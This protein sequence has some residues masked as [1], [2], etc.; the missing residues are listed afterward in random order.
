MANV[1][2]VWIGGS[3]DWNTPLDWNDDI[4]PDDA[5]TGSTTDVTL[6]GSTAYTVTISGGENFTVDSVSITDP[7]AMLVVD[8]ALTLT[9]T[10]TFAWGVSGA[11]TLALAG[12]SST[13][14]RGANL[15]VAAWSISGV[16]TSVSVNEA[17]TYSGSFSEA[18][19]ATLSLSGVPGT[20]LTLTGSASFTGGTVNG[21]RT[22]NTEGT[23]T[24]SGLTIGGTVAWTNTK[25]VTQSG[26]DVT[27]GDATGD[28]AKLINNAGA[29]YDITDASDIYRGASAQSSIHN[30][31]TF[32]K[33]STS[34]VS[35]IK[36]NFVDVGT[37]VC[38]GGNL[39]FD[40]AHNS[41][42]GTYIGP[43]MFDY[44]PDGVSTL[45][46]LDLTHS[47]C[48]TNFGVVD[49]TG[50]V[51]IANGST[52]KNLVGATWNF[53]GD[54]GLTLAAGSTFPSFTNLGAMAKTAG[55]GTSVVGI[56][57]TSSGTVAANTGT[58][59]F[60]GPSNSF[61]GAFRG[62]GQVA[63]TGGD[64]TIAPG[65]VATV[66]SLSETGAG[67]NVTM[68]ENLTYARAFSAG[69]G[70][71][72]NLTGGNLTLTGTDTFSGATI[73]GSHILYAE[74]A[75]AISGLTIGGTTIFD[76]TKSLTQSGGDVTVGDAGGDV[77]KLRNASTGTWDIADD[78]GIGLGSSALS[79]IANYGL[80]EKTGG[81]GTSAIAPSINNGGTIEVSSGT[82]DIQGTVTGTGM[83]KVS[84][85]SALEF[86]S[87]VSGNQ[88]VD[89]LGGGASA[90]DLLDPMG[91]SGKIAD[92]AS[93]DTI[94]LSGDWVFSGFS[95]N[96]GGT[97]GTL[98]LSSGTTKH[99]FTFVG[100]YAE[101]DFHITSG[102]NTIIAHM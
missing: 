63:F 25:T 52:I 49:V 34:G 37:V 21:A 94:D 9:G 23:T 61:S 59:A 96:S 36:V 24:V 1:N 18:A 32:A 60:H 6:S 28:V 51:T 15:S 33:T 2:A 39:Q 47:A 11:G 79:N 58:L 102:T 27:I 91:F 13:I 57:V 30:Y 7:L 26:G 81:T 41:L 71:T 73:S 85:A 99:A 5:V 40:G 76:N 68:G 98:T 83:D 82:L 84:G 45:A 43:G 89:F 87:P 48:S 16:G 101:G 80:F 88:T 12:G 97:L 38:A 67:T 56:D 8:G 92:F 66:A 90:V 93:P 100:D 3:A 4:V 77:A 17:L 72:L 46:N 62:A 75:T 22:L 20:P 19:G 70:A 10:S 95:E 69:S 54:F 29:T 55:T 53:V 78:S 64:T 44:G 42:S 14:T 65:A 31:G 74:G 50:L 35:I 86:D